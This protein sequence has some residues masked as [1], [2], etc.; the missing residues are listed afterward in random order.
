MD[1]SSKDNSGS[2]SK[3]TK[4]SALVVGVIAKPIWKYNKSGVVHKTKKTLFPDIVTVNGNQFSIYD[5]KYYKIK[6]DYKEVKK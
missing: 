5:T 3:N 4:Q 6:L 1:C 2:F